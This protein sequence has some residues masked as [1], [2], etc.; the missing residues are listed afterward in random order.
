MMQGVHTYPY[1]DTY[2]PAWIQSFRW[3]AG[4]ALP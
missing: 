4:F 3:L 2:K 1:V